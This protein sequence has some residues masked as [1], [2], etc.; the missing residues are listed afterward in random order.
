MQHH[1]IEQMTTKAEHGCDERKGRIIIEPQ[2]RGVLNDVLQN[3][4]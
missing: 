1:F 2:G 4:T 3:T